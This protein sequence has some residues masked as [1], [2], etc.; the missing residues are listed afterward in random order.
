MSE[1]LATVEAAF[2]DSYGHA[3]HH[4]VR[5]PGRVNLMGDHTDYNQGLVLP[6]AL[7]YHTMVAVSPRNDSHCEV[8]ALDCG[9][10]RDRFAC[11]QAIPF[12]S[13]QSWSNYVRGIIETLRRHDYPLPGCNLLIHGDIPQ[14]SGLSSSAALEVGVLLAVAVTGGFSIDRVAGARICQSAE[15]DFVGCACGIMDQLVCLCAEVDSALAI[16][17]RSLQYRAVKLPTDFRVVIIET[18]VRRALVAGEYNLRRQQC[19]QAASELGVGSLRDVSL[20]SFE[21]TQRHLNDVIARRAR[22][23]L[24]ENQR[25]LD[26]VSAFDQGDSL[27]VGHLMF[28]SHESLSR[29]YEVSTPEVDTLVALL[30]E[31]LGGHGGARM[32]GGGF[33]G[34]VVTLIPEN[35]CSVLNEVMTRYRDM[36]G[37]CATALPAEPS[38]A[39]GLL[40]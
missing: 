40:Y 19:E 26:M 28:Q 8:V 12:H 39:A 13:A 29:L 34:C 6:C 2:E 23:V 32:T 15:N 1:L 16:D 30:G 4:V 31:A 33:G 37:L 36:T 22:H 14:E 17:C 10:E 3:P 24:E 25:V 11:E 7:Q 20:V 21:Q 5:A 9:G 38:A 27:A 35:R 18:G